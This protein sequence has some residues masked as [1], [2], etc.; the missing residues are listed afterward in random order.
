[1]LP[2][3]RELLDKYIPLNDKKGVTENEQP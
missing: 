1:V 3:V 2:A